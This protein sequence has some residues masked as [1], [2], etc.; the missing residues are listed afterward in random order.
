MLRKARSTRP[1]PPVSTRL[2][3]ARSTQLHPARSTRLHPAPDS[4]LHPAPPDSRY[5]AFSTHYN[6]QRA[7]RLLHYR[8]L[9]FPIPGFNK[10]NEGFEH[11][12]HACWR[13]IVHIIQ[14]GVIRFIQF[15][16]TQPDH[17][18]GW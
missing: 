1:A 12:F 16:G 2:H 9:L 4:S 18:G 11:G 3:P 5:P 13:Q 7:S 17:T 14:A 6:P 10:V 8:R 15:A